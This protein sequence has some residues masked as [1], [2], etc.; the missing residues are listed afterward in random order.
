MENISTI[1]VEMW[2]QSE[3]EALSRAIASA[4]AARMDPTIEEVTEIKTAVSEAVSNAIIHGYEQ[5]KEGLI[6]LELSLSDNGRLIIAV[7]DFGIG[8]RDIEKAR[9][10]LFTT[11][12]ENER[13]GMG[14]TVMESFMDRVLVESKP[15]KGTRVTMIK[16]LD[17]ADDI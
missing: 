10:P 9:E 7:E 8:I 15:G 17:R 5:G 3:N 13:S 1:K 11:G 14:F 6:F 12:N 2:N 4:F 16:V